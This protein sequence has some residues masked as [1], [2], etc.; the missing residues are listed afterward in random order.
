MCE[1]STA[2]CLPNQVEVTITPINKKIYNSI[3]K[4]IYG[5]ENITHTV[6]R[7]VLAEPRVVAVRGRE[8]VRVQHVLCEVLVGQ[9]RA[10]LGHAEQAERGQRALRLLQV[11]AQRPQ[12]R[13]A[14]SEAK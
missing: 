14:H 1:P 13:V 4:M 6:E 12:E 7:V 11:G 10:R 9:Q 8:E 2:T 3:I 5:K